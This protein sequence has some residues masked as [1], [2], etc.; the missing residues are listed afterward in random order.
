MSIQAMTWAF[1]LKLKSSAKFVLICMCDCANGDGIFWPSLSLLQEKTCLD[2]KTIISAID[3]LEKDGYIIDTGKRRGGTSQI[4]VYSLACDLSNQTH[5]VYKLIAENGQFYIGVRSCYDLPEEDEYMGSGVWPKHCMAM[6]ISLEKEILAIYQTREQAEEDEKARIAENISDPRCQNR[7][8]PNSRKNGTVKKERETVPDFP[9]KSTVFPTK[10]YQISPERVPNLVHGTI[11]EPLKN[12]QGTVR[13]CARE[14]EPVDNPKPPDK[15][16]KRK[17]R[18]PENWFLPKDWGSWALEQGL[19]ESEIRTEAEC[20]AD[21]WRSKGETRADWQATW[22]NWI[23]RSK[24]FSRSKVPRRET[25]SE[26]NARIE[27][28]IFGARANDEAR[29]IDMETA[30]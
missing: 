3:S 17:T 24:T 10:E 29:T 11:N 5:Y 1:N 27:R 16:A 19:T 15:P 26:R 12:H 4:K 8:N 23:R 22:R 21:Y 6:N 2:R 28:E 7:A 13:E 30:A 25:I 9:S 14:P 20:F 18:L